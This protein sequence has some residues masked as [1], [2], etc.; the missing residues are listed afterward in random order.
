MKNWKKCMLITG[1]GVM[2]LA[3][4]VMAAPNEEKEISKFTYYKVG[5]QLKSDG[6]NFKGVDSKD[7]ELHMHGKIPNEYNVFGIQKYKYLQQY[8]LWLWKL[9]GFLEVAQEDLP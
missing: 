9:I 4:T 7:P 8:D 3:G 2:M 1:A 5:V 6:E